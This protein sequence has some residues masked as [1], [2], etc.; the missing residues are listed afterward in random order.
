VVHGSP[1][2]SSSICTGRS[3]L[4]AVTKLP[5]KT[6][7][8]TFKRGKAGS[9][10][11]RGA[12]PGIR[13]DL[14]VGGFVG[15]PASRRRRR[16]FFV[17]PGKR[18]RRPTCRAGR[19]RIG[20][21]GGPLGC[22]SWTAKPMRESWPCLKTITDAMPR[23]HPAGMGQRLDAADMSSR[24]GQRGTYRLIRARVSAGRSRERSKIRN[25]AA[26]RPSY[27]ST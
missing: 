12:K 27:Y 5:K 15:A 14:K 6:R 24:S 4:A 7:S 13:G 18:Q 17:F 16:S 20:A 23:P 9:P 26:R 25:T 3:Q 19:S 22:H 8:G 11:G 1:V 2:E 21:A 10:R